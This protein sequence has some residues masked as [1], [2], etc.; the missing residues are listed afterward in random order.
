MPGRFPPFLHERMQ[1]LTQGVF[2]RYMGGVST[3]GFANT[4]VDMYTTGSE[5]WPYVSAQWPSLALILRHLR[6]NGTFVDL[7]SGKGKALLMA[8]RHPYRRVVGVEIDAGLAEIA[9]LNIELTRRRRRAETVEC[10]VATV[11]DWRVPDDTS[12]VFMY[13]SFFGE[14]FRDA[15][16]CVFDS[17]N[18]NPRDLHIVY[19]FPWE[20][21]WLLS[22]GR[23]T[24]E[25]VHPEI[26]QA[27]PG[28][29]SSEQVTVVYHVTAA[30][31]HP[32]T[33]TV[34]TRRRS[35]ARRRALAR[36]VTPGEH[37]FEMPSIRG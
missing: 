33:C 13:N 25:D 30:G 9:R 22:T 31:Q 6:H 27:P 1:V 7:G 5:N 19:M 35:R 20:H 10:V 14:T 36:W 11:R 23:L 3:A 8:A 28:W 21:E 15:M 29:W 26:S 37:H 12:V 17:Y 32:G 4:S 34:G 2:D 16:G 18:R 24:V